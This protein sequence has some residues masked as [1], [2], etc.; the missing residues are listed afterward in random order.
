MIKQALCFL[1]F[2]HAF[3]LQTH[4]YEYIVINRALNTSGGVAFS[5]KIGANYAKQTLDSASKLIWKIFH[6]NNP[7][8]RK[9]VPKVIL[10]V[11][12]M[13]GVA[14]TTKR[15]I[16]LSARYVGN[17]KGGVKKEIPGVL[18]HEMVHVWQPYGNG[19]APGWLIEGLADYV[20]LK[21]NYA[22]GHWVKPG[23]GKK[24]DQ[25]YAVTARFLDYCES[26][27]TG[28]V[29]KLNNLS[30]RG[31]SDQHFVQLLGKPVDQLWRD[32]KAKYGNIA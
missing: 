30:R 21:A 11:D 19:G 8:D 14:Y 31:Y 4:A 1:V 16:H 20:R 28:F 24:W 5:D 15:E 27:K 12:D 9:N 29:G 17:Y 23:G 26:L 6:Q 3:H 22:A 18:Y 32:Y 10:F 7:Y 2:L 25:G 13:N